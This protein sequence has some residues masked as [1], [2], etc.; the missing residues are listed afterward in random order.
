[1]GSK[2]KPKTVY[3]LVT[4][5]EVYR[6][7]ELLKQIDQW[8]QAFLTGRLIQAPCADQN[9]LDEFEAHLESTLLETQKLAQHDL[10]F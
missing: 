5:T 6:T 2:H 1:M 10:E 4:E 3:Y 9:S 8:V 7:D